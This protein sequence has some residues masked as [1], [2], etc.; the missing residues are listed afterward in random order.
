MSGERIPFNRNILQRA[1]N[2]LN[3]AKELDGKVTLEEDEVKQLWLH[4][5]TEQYRNVCRRKHVHE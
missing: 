1:V 2:R 4:L 5:K 3:S